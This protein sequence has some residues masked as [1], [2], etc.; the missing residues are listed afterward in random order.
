MVELNGCGW[1]EVAFGTGWE[2]G[3]SLLHYTPCIAVFGR[4]VW[5]RI[6]LLVV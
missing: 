2:N 4:I 1:S 3:A 6:Y 5:V